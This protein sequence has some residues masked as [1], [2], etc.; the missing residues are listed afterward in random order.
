[1]NNHDPLVDS[2]NLETPKLSV[3]AK[4]PERI[5]TNRTAPHATGNIARRRMRIAGRMHG[6][7]MLGGVAILGSI[8]ILRQGL[9]PLIEAEFHPG[10]E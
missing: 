1:M 8:Q 7:L 5:E 4:S 10:P 9:L 2:L 3:G 6:S